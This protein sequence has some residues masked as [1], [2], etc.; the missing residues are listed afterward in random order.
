MD[1]IGKKLALKEKMAY[2]SPPQQ[3]ALSA[4]GSI[5][6]LFLYRGIIQL[7][8]LHHTDGLNSDTSAADN[9]NMLELFFDE[10]DNS[11]VFGCGL[12][13]FQEQAVFAVVDDTGL[14]SFG[15]LEEFHFIFR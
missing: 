11:I 6:P 14:E 15:N 4:E 1:T 8:S 3:L 12:D 9:F 7:L 5:F 13:E 10:F 2:G